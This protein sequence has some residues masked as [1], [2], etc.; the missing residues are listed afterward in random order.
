MCR[1]IAALCVLFIAS[2]AM[3]EPTIMEPPSQPMRH[4]PSYDNLYRP[5]N[6][7]WRQRMLRLGLVDSINNPDEPLNSRRSHSVV[8]SDL[9]A[10]PLW[11][12]ETA[13]LGTG[14]ENFV[15]EDVGLPK[16]R[17]GTRPAPAPQPQRTTPARPAVKPDTTKEALPRAEAPKADEPKHIVI[18]QLNPKGKDVQPAAKGEIIIRP[19]DIKAQPDASPIV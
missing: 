6:A 8:S 10:D 2:A 5:G 18:R 19:Y 1:L 4:N 12:Y 17:P 16:T 13:D 11:I 9:V 7:I 14:E 3:A 15:R